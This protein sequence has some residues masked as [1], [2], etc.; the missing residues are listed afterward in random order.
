M[1]N[2]V[3]ITLKKFFRNPLNYFI[4]ILVGVCF[5]FA[6]LSNSLTY[7][8]AKYFE[9]NVLNFVSYR[10][11]Y[12]SLE[13]ESE[14]ERLTKLLKSLP[15]IEGFTDD[16]G[17]MS[18][19]KITDIKD[20]TDTDGLANMILSGTA[21]NF[22]SD[23]GEDLTTSTEENYIVCPST[24]YSDSNR[25]TKIDLTPFIGNTL[26]IKSIDDENNKN[27]QVKLVGLYDNDRLNQN[28]RRCYINYNNLS[29]ISEES[30]NSK[31][32]TVYYE[33]KNIAYENKVN[34]ILENEGFYSMP[35]VA[36]ER[37]LAVE[38]IDMVYNISYL[39]I[40]LIL[41]VLLCIFLYKLKNNI[42]NV[43]M[44]KIL[45]YLNRSLFFNNLIETTALFISG[46]LFTILSLPIILMLFRKYIPILYP[47]FKYVKILISPTIFI[48]AIL[49]Y[50]VLCLIILFLNYIFS[51]LKK[52]N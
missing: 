32:Y 15:E 12:V 24:Y 14:Q 36:I 47:T 46:I 21:G 40:L 27:V 7:S 45:G 11:F 16:S 33:L 30:N 19:W 41:L 38:S 25:T 10:Q 22:H 1:I 43:K 13:R 29:K 39:L 9:D 34:K 26:T 28:Y 49:Y 17:Y 31:S 20:N 23:I 3:N 18:A 52:C 44:K 51:C 6:I 48:T 4:T 8:A 42:P 37:K 5:A 50:F 35:V 2:R